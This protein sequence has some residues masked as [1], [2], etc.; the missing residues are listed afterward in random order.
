MT[1]VS[2]VS[3]VSNS[4]E[5]TDEHVM[6]IGDFIKITS[7]DPELNSVWKIEYISPEKIVLLKI[8]DGEEK[9]MSYI[10]E[11]GVIQD[12]RIENIELLVK[13]GAYNAAYSVQR[14]LFPEKWVEIVFQ[15]LDEPIIGKI[16]LQANDSIDVSIY[17]NGE[18]AEEAFTL[19]FNYAG[20]PEG[21][22]SINIIKDPT[23]Y[24]TPV[25]E[26]LLFKEKEED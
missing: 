4:L 11:D 19:D 25:E 15:G 9:T 20:L 1:D 22:I 13:D 8:V 10:I 2:D 16:V 17:E 12:D 23:T 6:V 24:D 7:Q 5:E 3:D 14:E 21:V 18:L 26:E